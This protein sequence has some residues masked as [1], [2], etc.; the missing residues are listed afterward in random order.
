MSCQLGHHNSASAESWHPLTFSW[1]WLKYWD[2][3]Y[4]C[5]VN[6]R[7]GCSLTCSA[8][9]CKNWVVDKLSLFSRK[10]AA[11][12]RWKLVVW[13]S[14]QYLASEFSSKTF[15][16]CNCKQATGN[17]Q[18]LALDWQLRKESPVKGC[19]KCRSTAQ[20]NLK[21]GTL[22]NRAVLHSPIVG[23]DQ[24][25]Q[26]MSSQC[27]QGLATLLLVQV[28]ESCLSKERTQGQPASARGKQP[29]IGLLAGR[30]SVLGQGLWR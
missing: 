6:G 22:T 18:R 2:F 14:Y 16:Q 28:R 20:T 21:L 12:W 30:E 17:I 8:T 24:R 5:K 11:V 10:A 19:T 13:T 4:I 27:R 7:S 26:K 15:P 25:M 1:P 29:L 23:S 3:A 9:Q